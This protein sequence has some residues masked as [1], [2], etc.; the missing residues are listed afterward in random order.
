MIVVVDCEIG[1]L[2]SVQK[3]LENIGVEAEITADK[4]KIK[5]AQAVVLPGVGAFRDAIRSLR[6]NGLVEVL[7]DLVR[8]GTPVL[9]ICI[10]LQLFATESDEGGK[11]SGLDLVKGRV[12]KLPASV[13]VP[14][15]GWNRVKRVNQ[16]PLFEGVPDSAYF[17]FA[18]SYHIVPEEQQDIAATT[19]YGI[20]YVSAVW[21]GNLFGVQFHP[22]K[23]SDWGLKILK[24][25]TDLTQRV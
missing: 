25:F 18:H 19:E 23:S 12:V 11:Q 16:C 6:E 21:R 2:R 10:G 5:M 3:A 4:K 14:E 1:N 8:A 17:Y 9:G 7:S 15:M 24:N 13:K 22:E 20:D